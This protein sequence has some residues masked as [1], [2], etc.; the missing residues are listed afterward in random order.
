M[1]DF[2]LVINSNLGPDLHRLA[3]IHPWQTTDGRQPCKSSNV[4]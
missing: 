1:C 4:T 3:A 2:L